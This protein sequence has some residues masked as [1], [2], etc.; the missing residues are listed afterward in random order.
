MSAQPLAPDAFIHPALRVTG[1]TTVL[2]D[3][4]IHRNLDLVVPGSAVT[5]LLGPSGEGKSML[6]R[7][8]LGLIPVQSGQIE[9]FGQI[10]KNV[11]GKAGI[12]V[13]FQNGALFSN[14]TVR[15]NVMLA[16]ETQ[17]KLNPRLLRELAD[18]KIQTVGLEPA[19]AN[20][21]PSQLS[22]GMRK[23]AALARALA[24]DPP[25]LIL[26]EPT[27]GLD[28]IAADEFDQ[29]LLHLRANIDLSVLMVTHDLD[30]FARVVDW[31]LV[32]KGGRIA[33]AGTPADLQH[34]DDEWVRSFLGGPRGRAALA[35]T[36]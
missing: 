33:A 2:G 9:I 17:V 3:R 30:S 12:G 21:K 34:S 1:L 20:R 35:A 24:L 36:A 25:L 13:L 8:I 22:G 16:I 29:L 27:A 4:F 19:A 6:L 28:P 14:L 32:L 18:M 23:R 11:A 31:G 10:Q 26:D 15:E 7:A 5:A